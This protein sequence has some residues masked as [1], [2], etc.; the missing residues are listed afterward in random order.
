MN[1]L[2]AHRV[3]G[4]DVEFDMVHNDTIILVPVRVER[5]WLHLEMTY[6]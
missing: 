3:V 5:S 1:G 2:P 6:F 4:D